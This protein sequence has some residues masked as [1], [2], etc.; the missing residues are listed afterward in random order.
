VQTRTGE[1]IAPRTVSIVAGL[2]AAAV[3]GDTEPMAGTGSEVAGVVKVKGK[4]FDD[5]RVFDTVTEAV[6][7]N[8]AWA[9]EMETVICVA[10]TKVVVL[11]CGCPF[12]LTTESLV[13]FVPATVSVKPC[14]LQ[15]GVEA[16]EVVDAEREV[17]AGG[18]PGAALI[19]K[20]MMFEISV[21]VVL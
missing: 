18:G 9:A 7:G 15:K 8:A 1:L 16:C 14:G 12:Q 11:V 5:P 10:L 4:E 17:I 13:K 6:P 2:P 20:R 19:L 21:V 3:F